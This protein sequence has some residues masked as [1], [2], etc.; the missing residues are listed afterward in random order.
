[1]LADVMLGSEV[2]RR[3]RGQGE[4]LRPLH[5]LRERIVLSLIALNV[6]IA[7]LIAFF[8]TDYRANERRHAWTDAEN[9]QQRAPFR[10]RRDIFAN[11]HRSAGSGGR[12]SAS[13]RFRR[14]ST[15]QRSRL[16]SIGRRRAC[17]ERRACAWSTPTATCSTRPFRTRRRASTS[18]TASIFASFRTHPDSGL[19]ISKPELDRL[20][21]QLDC[22]LRPTALRP[23]W[24]V[25]RRSPRLLADR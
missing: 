6:I 4:G 12:I 1:M 21:K 20:I 17:R 24:R 22:D 23:G 15:T 18:P 25:R 16:C 10:P 9:S 8:L 5:A 3:M 7:A 19:V 13:A 2:R 14:R 11:R